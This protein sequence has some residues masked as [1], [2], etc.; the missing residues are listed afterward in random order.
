MAT[1]MTARVPTTPE[2]HARLKREQKRLEADT[3]DDAIQKLLDAHAKADGTNK[4]ES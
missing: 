3:F 2:T 4:G 1:K